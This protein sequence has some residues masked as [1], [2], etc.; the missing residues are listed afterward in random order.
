MRFHTQH[1]ALA[2]LQQPGEAADWP[3]RRPGL[4]KPVSRVEAALFA[5]RSPFSKGVVLADEIG[6]G[7]RIEG[8]LLLSQRK[9]NRTHRVLP[10]VPANEHKH[11]AQELADRFYIPSVILEA[12]RL[13][14][15]HTDS[16]KIATAIKQ[17]VPPY[18]ARSDQSPPLEGPLRAG[19]DV[20]GRVR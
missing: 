1:R 13:G 11:W 19:G 8:G 20:I 12:H 16:S 4:R 6:L 9:L 15:V 14:N 18:P 17:A 7:K 10:I 3:D 5:F 2:L